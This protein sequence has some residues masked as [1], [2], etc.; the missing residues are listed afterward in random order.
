MNFINF[1]IKNLNYI[2]VY[3]STVIWFWKTFILTFL[4]DIKEANSWGVIQVNML[5]KSREYQ[6]GLLGG[7]SRSGWFIKRCTREGQ[8]SM[9]IQLEARNCQISFSGLSGGYACLPSN[10]THWPAPR[11]DNRRAG[12]PLSRRCLPA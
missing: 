3:L 11:K 9:V 4:I 1:F 7:H 6:F 2:S 8:T 12:T 5:I 10:R